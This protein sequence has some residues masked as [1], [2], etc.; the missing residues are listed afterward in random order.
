[1]STCSARSAVRLCSHVRD[2]MRSDLAGLIVDQGHDGLLVGVAR[3]EIG[4]LVGVT[5]AVTATEPGLVR[6][7]VPRSRPATGSRLMASRIRCS[8]C[9]ALSLVM[10][11]W[12]LISHAEMLFLLAK[13]SK[14]T[15]TTFG[16]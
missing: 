16:C 4:A 15:A 7:M 13:I 10:L 11:Y 1:M 3:A 12:R 14:M 6:A 5:V 9:H 2:V 8:M